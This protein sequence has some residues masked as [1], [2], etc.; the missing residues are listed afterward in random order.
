MPTA[1][2][3]P[4]RCFRAAK[5]VTAARELA[6]VGR[7]IKE[8]VRKAP[9]TRLRGPKAQPTR[10]RAQ[11]GTET[12]NG[13]KARAA[14]AN[15]RP[16]RAVKR[17]VMESARQAERQKARGTA[18]ERKSPRVTATAST[19]RVPKR[20]AIGADRVKV[21]ATLGRSRRRGVKVMRAA[22]G[23]KDRRPAGRPRLRRRSATDFRAVPA[24]IVSGR[25]CRVRIS[26]ATIDA[27]RG[28]T[29]CS[30]AM[31]RPADHSQWDLRWAANAR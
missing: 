5:D 19:D 15:V 30:A 3:L 27:R 29:R 18:S 24:G 26:V 22:R 9:A 14:T 17:A 8:S 6:T 28:P 4:R 16:V 13:R 25:M 12:G 20:M 1:A 23:Q 10:V 7:A 11:K 2:S 31:V 21:S